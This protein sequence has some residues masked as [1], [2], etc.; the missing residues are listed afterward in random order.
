ML[1]PRLCSGQN[2]EY[3]P[4]SPLLHFISAFERIAIL[5]GIMDCLEHSRSAIWIQINTSNS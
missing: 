1:G 4:V 2:S 5:Y 3:I